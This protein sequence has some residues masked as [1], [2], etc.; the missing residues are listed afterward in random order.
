MIFHRLG[1]ARPAGR[2]GTVATMATSSRVSE[3]IAVGGS[4]Y[5]VTLAGSGDPVV[6]CPSLGRPAADFD[7]LVARL[8]EAGWQTIAVDPPGI[9][10]GAPTW[11]GFTLHDLAAELWSVVDAVCDGVVV[12]VGHAFGNR[13]VRTAS[14]DRPDRVRGIVLAGCGGEVSPSDAVW[15]RLARCFDLELDP[16]EHLAAVA[17]SF[18]APGN[19]PAPWRDHWYPDLAGAQRGAVAATDPADYA[20]GGTGPGLVLQGLDDVIAPPENAWRLVARRPRTRVVGLPRCGHAM[21]P[22]QPRAIGDAVL[23][24]LAE[25]AG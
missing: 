3:R 18:F 19:D 15:A 13:L 6:L 4:D 1:S 22:E 20:L 7:A 21:L 10:T 2:D 8:V 25:L 24:F 12:L 5:V 14:G 9:S 17:A 23:S 16:A 11:A